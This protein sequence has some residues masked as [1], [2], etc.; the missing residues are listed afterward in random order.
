MSRATRRRRRRGDA[1]QASVFLIML[2]PVVMVVFALVWEAGQMLVAKAELLTVAHTAAR[3]GA[4]QLDTAATVENGVPVLDREGATRVAVGHLRSA[5][6]AGGAE[7]EG[8]QVVVLARTV[9]TP[10]LLPIG[11]SGIEAE[12]TA[13]ALQPP[14]R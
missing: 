7:V 2:V 12:A 8:D 13:T 3:A 4:H 11:P 9:Y 14:P 1:G 10:A 5:G 6:S